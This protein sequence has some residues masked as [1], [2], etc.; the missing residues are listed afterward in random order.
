ME[1]MNAT[2]TEA[3]QHFNRY[4]NWVEAA[5]ARVQIVR[6]DRVA[7]VLMS[8]TDAAKLQRLESEQQARLEKE[9]AQ[10]SPEERAKIDQRIW[11]PAIRALMGLPPLSPAALKALRG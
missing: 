6:H 2:A 7:A 5:G 3:R 11:D 10:Y 4:V 9:A 1:T 8:A